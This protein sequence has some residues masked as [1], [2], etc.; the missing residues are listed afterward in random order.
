L[1]KIELESFTWKGIANAI[2]Q[3]VNFIDEENSLKYKEKFGILWKL[4]S[5]DLIDNKIREEYNSL[6]HGFRVTAGGFGI[7]VG[8]QDAPDIPAPPE[9]MQTIGYSKFGST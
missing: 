3:N 4:L 6:K 1:S 5:N 8:L 7:A 2:F 9:R